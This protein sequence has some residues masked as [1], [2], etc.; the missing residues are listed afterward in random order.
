M[1]GQAGA[2]HDLTADINNNN[3]GP[4]FLNVFIGYD[5]VRFIVEEVEKLIPARDDKGTYL[6]AAFIKFQIADFSQAFTVF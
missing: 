5:I 4:D 6:P 3:I 2:G 1:E